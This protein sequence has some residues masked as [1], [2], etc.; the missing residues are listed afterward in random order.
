M[1]R[2][3]LRSLHGNRRLG[4]WLL[5]GIVA[6]ALVM[7]QIAAAAPGITFVA[8]AGALAYPDQDPEGPVGYDEAP[9]ALRTT[10]LQPVI[11]IEADS[12]TQLECHPNSIQTTQPCG[13][14]LPGCA[15]AVCASYQPSAPL[16]PDSSP[17]ST[18]NFLAVDLLD[19]SGDTLA[20]EWLKLD[21]DTTAPVTNLDDAGTNQ[22]DNPFRPTF[23]F[24]VTDSNYVGGVIDHA[25]CAWTSAA[26]TPSWSACRLT[27]GAGSFSPGVL[28]H[29][30]RLY[31]LSVRGVDDFGRY[32]T[33]SSSYDPVPCALSVRRPA[34]LSSM[35][36]SGIRVR[37]S[38]DTLSHAEVGVYAYALNGKRYASPRG[39]VSEFPQLGALNIHSRATVFTVNRRL[40]LYG[41]ARRS[42]RSA[43][44][45]S[46]VL[47]AGNAD[48]IDAGIADDTLSY[49]TLTLHR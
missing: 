23:T 33:A 20:S 44:S 32:T 14:P 21:V 26:Q 47:A 30:H 49:Q 11:G 40:T 2:R 13:P 29:R 1:A 22:V 3:F 16:T 37:V 17:L 6:V 27:N 48:V 38:C 18:G 36:S 42:F 31:T 4:V 15:A 41:A 39:A 34:R 35:L 9:N 12:G 10:Q 5:P 19:A 7:P 25:E 46:V 28:P 24:L 43:R 8:P 45:L